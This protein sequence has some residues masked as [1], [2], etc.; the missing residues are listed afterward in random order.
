MLKSVMLAKE[1]EELLKS[2]AADLLASDAPIISEDTEDVKKIR[3]GN[4]G[5][6]SRDREG[7]G[8]EVHVPEL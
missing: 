5:E 2:V 4:D 6:D 3:S 1:T 7:N 8:E